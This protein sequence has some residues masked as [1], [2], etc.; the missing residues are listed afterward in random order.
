MSFNRLREIFI[1]ITTG[2]LLKSLADSTPP[3]GVSFYLG[4]V[5]TLRIWLCQP[6]GVS[7]QAAAGIQIN[8]GDQIV[9][10][11]KSA[12]NLTAADALYA[13]T[14]FAENNDGHGNY[15]YEAAL[16]LTGAGLATALAATGN[17]QL[18]TLADVKIENAGN[19]NR[20]TF[21]V[22]ITVRQEAYAGTEGTTGAGDPVYPAPGA[23]ALTVGV[24]NFMPLITGKTGGGATNIDGIATTTLPVDY[25]IAAPIAGLGFWLLQAGAAAGGEIAP[26][27]YDAGTNNKKWIKI[28]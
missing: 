11:G 26:A 1:D 13:A 5:F 25:L 23:L 8:A 4:D 2:N 10:A 19:T 21:Q 28:L 20:V 15:F 14:P 3:N 17:N 12:N 16:D 22:P 27:D 7:G 6:S 9:F 18:S 24:P